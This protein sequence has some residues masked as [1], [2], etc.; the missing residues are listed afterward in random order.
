MAYNNNIPLAADQLSVSQ[1]DLL[2]N[3]ATI[4]TYLNVNHVDFNGADQGK[5]KLLTLPVQTPAAP[6]VNLGEFGIALILLPF[7]RC[8]SEPTET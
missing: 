4:S 1:A 5:H 8:S 3:F 2:N 7:C 6:T